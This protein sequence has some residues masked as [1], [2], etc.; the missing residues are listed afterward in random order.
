MMRVVSFRKAV[1]A[2]AC[3]AAVMEL[4]TLAAAQAGMPM[5][6]FVKALS[7]VAFDHSPLLSMAAAFAVHLAIGICWA[8]FYAFFFWGRM[9]L[10]PPVQGLVFAALPAAL[11]MFIVYPELDRD[12]SSHGRRGLQRPWLPFATLLADGG[13]P[14]DRPR[15]V[16]MTS[17]RFTAARSA[18]APEPS[19]LRQDRG[20]VRPARKPRQPGSTAFMFATGIECSYPTIDHGR[21]R[22][23]ELDLAGHYSS[24]QQDFELAREIGITHIRYGPPLHLIFERRGQYNWDYCDPSSRSCAIWPRTDRRP[25]PFRRAVVARQFPEWRFPGRSPNMPAH[26]PSVTRGCASI[27]RSTRCTCAPG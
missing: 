11:A 2:G 1:I 26:L 17:A 12:A 23:D 19:R 20:R 21:W 10:P 7:S 22:R 6:D 27:R 14:A 8:I 13:Q 18:I 15:F 9:K 4:V 25:V 24:W 16:R 3:G 5:M